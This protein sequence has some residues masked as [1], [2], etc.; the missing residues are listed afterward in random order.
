MGDSEGAERREVVEI[1][2]SQESL[3]PDALYNEGM[4][5]YRRRRWREAKECFTRL[6]VLQPSRRVDALLRELDIF[7]QLELV[8]AETTVDVAVTDTAAAEGRAE[9]ERETLSRAGRRAWIP[10]VATF[11]VLGL[12]GAALYLVLTG[13]FPSRDQRVKNL[14][15]LGEAYMV[16]Q[17]Y[18][19]ALRIYAEL[20]PLVP[21]D[22]EAINGVEKAKAKLYDEALA[23][24]KAN[25]REQAS[26]DLRCI[27]ERDPGYKDVSSLIQTLDRR[28]TLE[29]DYGQARGYLDSRACREAVDRLE[30]LRATDPEYNPGTVSDALYEAYMCL[31]QQ[32]TGLVGS[33][34]KL[35]PT[36][37]P[38]EPGWAIT[39]GVLSN[40]LEASRA[41]GK[42][43][44]ERSNSEEAKLGKSLADSL[45]Q[46]LESY[47]ASAW[48]ECIPPLLEVYSQD[49]GYLSGKV[50]A[51]ICDAYLHL[52]DVY[53]RNGDYHAA[54]KDYQMVL[55]I[56]GCDPQPAQTRAQEAGIYLTPS[57]TPTLTPTFTATPTATA[58][59]TPRPTATATP[60]PTRT[61]TPTLTP[62]TSSGGGPSPVQAT[63]PPIIRPTQPPPIRP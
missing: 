48:A 20:L 37:K 7:L 49:A 23:Y 1:E 19:K 42:A 29:A 11:A 25:N 6:N 16:A 15:N 27:F 41:F 46:G 18:C 62:T 14:R 36:A 45:K 4:A 54:L 39:Q 52:G 32:F 59:R 5:Y 10:W 50:A 35:S 22:P 55:K 38:T 51:L 58:T 26:S 17:Q 34:L 21:G 24:L 3:D 63:E 43:L 8:E 9:R 12:V 61:P 60:V 53:Y 40:V 47:S 28:Q 57:P 33:E 56:Q 30:K 44:K 31:A 2:E 13:R